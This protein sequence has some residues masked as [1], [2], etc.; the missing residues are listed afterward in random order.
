M[1]VYISLSSSSNEKCRRKFVE[2]I[3]THV[4]C[5]KIFSENRAFCEIMLEKYGTVTKAMDDNIIRRVRI[6]CRIRNATDIFKRQSN[7]VLLV[8]NILA[9]NPFKV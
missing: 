1:Y 9:L 4:I 7:L 5:S 3:K 8:R 2:K 6:A